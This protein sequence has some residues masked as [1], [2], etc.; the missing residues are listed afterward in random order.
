[1]RIDHDYYLIVDLEATCTNDGSFPSEEMEIIEIGAVRQHALT[2]EMEDAFQTF[3]RPVRHPQLTEFCR[4]LTS[5]SQHDVD[6]APL[7][8][9][10]LQTFRDWFSGYDICFASWGAYDRKQFLQDCE[11]HGVE[12]PFPPEHLNVKAAFSE[13]RNTRHRYG[14]GQAMKKLGLRFDGTPHRGI[15]DARNIARLVRFMLA[16]RE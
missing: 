10:A 9:Q 12:Y 4:Q 5:I 3:V 7:F 15:D 1:M 11:Y 14:L 13:L 8:P 6:A 2:L 16:G